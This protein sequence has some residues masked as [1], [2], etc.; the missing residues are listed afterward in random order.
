M[1]LESN[2]W[3]AVH[4]SSLRELASRK[5]LDGVFAYGEYV[6][7]YKPADCHKEMIGILLEVVSRAG[8]DEAENIVVLEPRGHAKTTW[9]DTI[10]LSW[11]VG[12]FPHLRIGLMSKTSQHAHDFS[13]AIRWTLE[14]NRRHKEIFGESVSTSKWTDAEWLHR[15]S[16]WHGS[17]NVTLFAQGAGGQIASKRFDIILCDDILD[18]ENTKTPEQ[19]ADV[20]LWFWKPLK[21]CL[22]P[23]GVVIVLGTRWAEDDIYQKLTDPVDKGGRGWRY[24]L[25]KAIY[26]P[27]DVE[28]RPDYIK[29]DNIRQPLWGDYWTLDKLDLERADMGTALF[30]CAYQNDIRGLT[31]GNI[32]LGR[33]FQYYG[34]LDPGRHYVV[35]MGIDLASSEKQTADF[36]ARVTTAEDE[37]GNFY[38]MAVY[39]DRRET[40]HAEFVNDG[41]MAYQN[42]SIVLVE[43]NAFQS[44]LIQEV[45]SDYPRIPIEGKP[46]DTDKI[47]R[48]RAVAAKYEGHK[49]W[50]HESLRGSDFELELLAFRP[51]ATHDDMVDALGFSMDL[52]GGNF[53][54]TSARRH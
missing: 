48:G 23:G 36:T 47:T 20:E 42:V 34:Q 27:G 30:S 37:D 14:Y 17:N 32:F 49:V 9:G 7:G 5:T 8:T 2:Q 26:E 40:G 11:L 38:V 33:N 43:K 41:F 15:D 1:E 19:R 31:E 53:S 12:Q 6:F 51:G 13:R 24:V 44:T 29:N 4:S 39:R 28:N 10:F 16:P 21:P 45:L 46:T 25:R 18:E 50:H 3:D 52:A 54:F 22:A 35:R